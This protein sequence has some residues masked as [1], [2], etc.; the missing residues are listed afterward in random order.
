MTII[1][2]KLPDQQVETF[3]NFIKL[4]P[5]VKIAKEYTCSELNEKKAEVKTKIG[6]PSEKSPRRLFVEKCKEVGRKIGEL[7]GQRLVYCPKGIITEYTFHFNDDGFCRL[8]DIL[9]QE[10][11]DEIDAYLKNVQSP[12]GISIVLPFVGKILGD[13]IFSSQQGLHKS[14]LKTKLK[15]VY[16]SNNI[17]KFLSYD[18]RKDRDV[19]DDLFKTAVKMAAE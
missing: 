17:V 12:D 7:N 8:M 5:E 4:I 6:K 11:P 1:S 9:N 15:D 10:C 19:L 14:S 18:R 16:N 13:Y 2:I 3:K